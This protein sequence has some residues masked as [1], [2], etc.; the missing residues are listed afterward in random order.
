VKAAVTSSRYP[1][2]FESGC[3]DHAAS[4]SGTKAGDFRSY[5]TILSLSIAI[6][7]SRFRNDLNALETAL[8]DGRPESVS[9]ALLERIL[10]FDPERTAASSSSASAASAGASAGAGAAKPPAA[11][12]SLPPA[13]TAIVRRADVTAALNAQSKETIMSQALKSCSLWE[14]QLLITLAVQKASI[15][16]AATS[17]VSAGGSIGRSIFTI[18]ELHDRLTNLMNA[19]GLDTV[20]APTHYGLPDEEVPAWFRS[21][22]G[23]RPRRGGAAAGNNN[24]V[25]AGKADA[26]N[27]GEEKT[28][29][30]TE[31]PVP[32]GLYD[33]V[34][35]SVG[36]D[37][38]E[39]AAAGGSNRKPS[40]SLSSSSSS[41]SSSGAGAVPSEDAPAL[42]LSSDHNERLMAFLQNEVVRLFH[43]AKVQRH[44]FAASSSSG[45]LGSAVPSI[46]IAIPSVEELSYISER[47]RSLG[48]V[49]LYPLRG[50]TH[51]MVSLNM[52]IE[53]IQDAYGPPPMVVGADGMPVATSAASTAAAEKEKDVFGLKA[54]PRQR[55]VA[56]IQK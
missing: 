25:G 27:G 42:A 22:S 32:L 36:D 53:T 49:K 55:L 17:S 35:P 50:A 24:S 13:I 21:L 14:R 40:A 56:G 31:P 8:K 3:L 43:E 29:F 16:S 52:S 33:G 1:P 6:A 20:Q 37:S 54:L 51:P 48:L 47:L 23:E 2:I 45:A 30:S 34:M 7:E 5:V 46:P 26:S 38:S 28:I 39:D 18:E 19:S 9:R 44:A 12:A 4:R 10:A 11:A 41:S 15:S